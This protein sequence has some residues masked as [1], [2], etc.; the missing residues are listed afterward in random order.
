[1]ASAKVEERELEKHTKEYQ[2]YG[3][4]VRIG[5]DKSGAPAYEKFVERLK[6]KKKLSDA[7][8]EVK[9][10]EW[11]LNKMRYSKGYGF[12][13]GAYDDCFAIFKERFFSGF[14]KEQKKQKKLPLA[15]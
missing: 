5:L 8:K 14:I 6:K 10:D 1:M 11:L 3:Y 4:V 15:N 13:K 2:V 12:S 7:Q 9:C